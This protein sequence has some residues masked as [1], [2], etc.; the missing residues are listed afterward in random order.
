MTPK[1]V[2]IHKM[3]AAV[4]EKPVE[5]K[6]EKHSIINNKTTL[7]FT[8]HQV[9]LCPKLARSQQKGKINETNTGLS[10]LSL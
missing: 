6:T 7:K 4:L 8:E 1:G 9:I 2:G 5:N 10:Q 3:R